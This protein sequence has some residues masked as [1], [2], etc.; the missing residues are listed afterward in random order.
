MGNSNATV[1]PTKN[2]DQNVSE[3]Y[4]QREI[5]GAVVIERSSKKLKT[6]ANQD[7]LVTNEST[8]NQKLIDSV[9]LKQKDLEK[10]LD[11]LNNQLKERTNRINELECTLQNSNNNI[12]EEKNEFNKL[13][14][15]LKSELNLKN[16][17]IQLQEEKLLIAN[18]LV[19][20]SSTG[21]EALSIVI[22]NYIT[23]VNVFFNE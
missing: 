18:G 20:R 11:N 6:K 1:H 4:S 9:L 5:S 12:T 22:Q 19:D 13:S 14:A 15:D 23:Q 10:Q 16:Q 3:L 7:G 21:I 2:I 17:Q 8:K